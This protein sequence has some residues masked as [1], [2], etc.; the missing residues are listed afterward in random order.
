MISRLVLALSFLGITSPCAQWGPPPP[1]VQSEKEISEL[2][3][4]CGRKAQEIT[5]RLND[6]LRD[7]HKGDKIT[8]FNWS[9]AANYNLEERACFVVVTGLFSPPIGLDIIKG[10][11]LFEVNL[12]TGMDYYLG[13][14]DYTSKGAVFLYIKDKKIQ[15][16]LDAALKYFNKKMGVY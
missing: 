4:L 14:L 16:N 12:S 9:H 5:K 7:E 10:D 15:D 3:K 2:K 6:A 8:Q 1:Y 13:S 11:T